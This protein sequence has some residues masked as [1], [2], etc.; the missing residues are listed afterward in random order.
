MKIICESKKMEVY[1]TETSITTNTLEG[2][3]SV[4]GR[5]ECSNTFCD[6]ER[7]PLD[8]QCSKE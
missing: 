8:E 3:A 5:K 6:H 4:P 2:G 1:V 7:C